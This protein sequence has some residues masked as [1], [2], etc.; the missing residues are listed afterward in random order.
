MAHLHRKAGPILCSQYVID[1]GKKRAILLSACGPKTYALIRNLTGEKPTTKS[2]SEIV[3]LVETAYDPRPSVIV[4]RFKFNSRNRSTEET[5]STYVAALRNLAEHC[6]FSDLAEML[7][8]RLVC[9]INHS[10]IQ[11]RLLSVSNLR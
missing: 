8:D 9:G 4:Q 2:Y 10:G 7:R 5:V 1:A 6:K 3:K 11:K